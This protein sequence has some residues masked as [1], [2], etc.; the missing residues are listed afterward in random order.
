MDAAHYWG[1]TPDEFDGRPQEE[2]ARMIAFRIAAQR[3][4][5]WHFEQSKKAADRKR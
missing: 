3:I 2:K 5:G 1:L 4:E